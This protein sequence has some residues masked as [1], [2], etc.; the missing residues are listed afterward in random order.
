M[1]DIKQFG[2]MPGYG[3]DDPRRFT[4]QFPVKVSFSVDTI[5]YDP[6]ADFKVLMQSEP[7]NLYIRFCNMVHE[8]KDNFD[9]ILTY[10][11]RLLSL[12]QAAEFC[13][14]G[15]WVG[16]NIA[17]DKKNEISFIM[18]SKLNGDAYHMRF[19]ILRMIEQYD[20]TDWGQFTIN[21][22][23]SPGRVPSKDPFFSSAKF[24]IACE[25]QIMTNMFTEKILDCFKTY[26]V[27]IYYGCTNIDK[28]FN[29]KGILR[30][31]SIDEFKDI[32]ANLTPGLY[33]ELMPYM[34]ENYELGR[35]YWEKNI[36]ERIED[37][38][39]KALNFNLAQS[40]ELFQHVILD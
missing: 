21:W 1:Y 39:E 2:Y 31:N 32:I 20:K 9:L 4:K 34:Q 17:L 16:D 19:M 7:P 15:S 29:P 14:V 23:R 13:P 11:D 10:D 5:N 27:P 37:E 24:N 12:P 33:D 38:I 28:Y 26:T 36:Y 40:S 30:F 3:V 18:S 25:N 6:G 8:N 22:H 35:K